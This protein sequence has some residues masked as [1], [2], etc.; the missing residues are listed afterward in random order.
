MPLAVFTTTQWQR[1]SWLTTS[2]VNLI[3]L[4]VASLFWKAVLDH[5]PAV[6]PSCAYAALTI[7]NANRHNTATDNPFLMCTSSSF[8]FEKS[9]ERIEFKIPPPAP[10][11]YVIVILSKGLDKD[12]FL[13]WRCQVFRASLGEKT[14][15]P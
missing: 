4:A 15:G 14:P 11:H 1:G 7:T 5:S 10:P 9:V 13:I 2:P 3:S 8:G 6:P 12:T